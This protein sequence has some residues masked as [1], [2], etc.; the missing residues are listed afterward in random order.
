[1]PRGPKREKVP[2]DVIGAAITVARISFGDAN[3]RTT[4][5]SGRVPNGSASAKA[6][7]GKMRGE[8]RAAVA[9]KTASARCG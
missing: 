4:R 7:A 1:M 2:A 5:P 3:E 6:R 8:D 9:R